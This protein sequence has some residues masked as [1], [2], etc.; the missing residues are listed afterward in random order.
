M[1]LKAAIL[2]T[3]SNAID[4]ERVAGY[5]D[6]FIEMDTQV[7]HVVLGDDPSRYFKVTL[8]EVDESEYFEASEYDDD[9]E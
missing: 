6:S 7:I 9:D 2:N 8:T 1:N 4:E 5:E 3:I